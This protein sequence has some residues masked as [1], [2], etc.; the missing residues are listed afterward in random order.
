MAYSENI[1]QN[2][3][4]VHF[5]GLHADTGFLK[6]QI[7]VTLSSTLKQGSILALDGSELAIADAATAVYVIDDFKMRTHREDVGNTG[8]RTVV[9]LRTG[10]EL[11]SDVVTF[12]DGL[13]DTAGKAAL[14]AKGFKFTAPILDTDLSVFDGIIS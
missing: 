14:V 9:V 2:S 1:D 13:V 4:V 6:D 7:T 3:K 5:G 12:S 10:F 11:N 8:T